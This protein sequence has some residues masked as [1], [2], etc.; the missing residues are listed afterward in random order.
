[1]I[2]WQ[3]KT[4]KLLSWAG[5]SCCVKINTRV[6]LICQSFVRHLSPFMRHCRINGSETLLAP[7]HYKR[8]KRE[9][10]L[11][12]F[13]GIRTKIRELSR[14]FGPFLHFL[15]NFCRISANS[16][17]EFLAFFCP[18]FLSQ[19][20][21]F[22]WGGQSSPRPASYAYVYQTQVY[23]SPTPPLILLL[24]SFSLLPFFSFVFSFSSSFLLYFAN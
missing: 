14:K 15:L 20:S 13:W 19:N 6:E 3:Q 2:Y 12:H 21:F 8:A 11:A 24:F 18:N 5:W 17:P 1:M 16:V 22:F 7:N 9:K 10:I 23:P 4:G